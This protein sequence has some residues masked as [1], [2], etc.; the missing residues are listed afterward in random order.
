MMG[1]GKVWP[2]TPRRTQVSRWLRPMALTAR[3]TCP[4]PACGSGSSSKRSASR[5]P[6][7]RMTMAFMPDSSA[8]LEARRPLLLEGCEALGRVGA[9]DQPLLQL[10]LQREVL[11]EAHLAAAH[12]R[13]L[14]EPHGLRRLVRRAELLRARQH[15][16]EEGGRRQ[17]LVHQPQLAAALEV[18]V[19]ALDH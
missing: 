4:A 18:H 14:D 1:R 5:S 19:L 8:A 10:A 17:Q 16:V 12:D 3:R 15:R 11:V 13:A 6:C 9:R 2:G 7:S